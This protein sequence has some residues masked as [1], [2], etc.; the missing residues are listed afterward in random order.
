MFSPYY[1]W[2]RRGASTANPENFV[3]L[4]VALYMPQ[5]KLWCMTERG[6]ESLLRTSTQ[7]VIGRSGIAW[8]GRS[9]I[10][11]VDEIAVP[12]PR[13]VRGRIEV[14]PRALTGETFSLDA[15]R[16][17]KWWPIAPR[18]AVRAEF[19]APRWSWTGH[20]YLDCNWGTEPLENAFTSWSWSRTPFADETLLLYDARERSGASSALALSADDFGNVAPVA[21]HPLTG[22]PASAWRLPR[23]TRSEDVPRLV[24]G[25]EDGPFYARASVETTWRG[26]TGIGMHEALSLDRFRMRPVQAM[27]P[28]RMPRWR[29]AGDLAQRR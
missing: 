7:L 8:T 20:G 3:S 10:I 21:P 15:A 22:L 13:R 17:H 14:V 23:E 29:H 6:S 5:R 26:R 9:L 18:A 11:D 4:N 12:F 19:E 28:F 16:N 25:L 24:R 1:A 2:A 27:L